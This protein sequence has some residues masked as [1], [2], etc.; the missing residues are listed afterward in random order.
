MGLIELFEIMP[1]KYL[2]RCQRCNFRI[3]LFAGVI[4]FELSLY[5]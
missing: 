1:Y 2:N 4:N 5:K 3:N